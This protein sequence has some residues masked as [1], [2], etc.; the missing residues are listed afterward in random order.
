MP[1]LFV[2]VKIQQTAPDDQLA[3]FEER[4]ALRVVVG[5]DG[6]VERQKTDTTFIILTQANIPARD[7]GCY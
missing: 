3:K 5:I 4:I 7:L 2:S 1:L 6:F